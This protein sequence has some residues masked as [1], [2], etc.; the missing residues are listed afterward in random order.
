MRR[1]LALLLSTAC[2]GPGHYYPC[3][4]D[5]GG[6]CGVVALPDGGRTDTPFV[7]PASTVWHDN[8]HDAATDV[9]RFAG[10]LYVAFRHAAAWQADPAAQIFIVRSDD[11]GQSWS[12]VA[13]LTAAG[14]DLREP[15]IFLF[16]D[17]L[18]VI[19]T[20]WDTSDPSAHRTSIRTAFSDDGTKFTMPAD[21]PVPPGLAAWRPRVV[22][23]ALVL[24][25]WHADE[26]F[27][28]SASNQ[29][30]LLT[31]PDG[32]LFAAPPAPLTTSAGA[33]QGEL[34]V[35]ASG[36]SWL[37]LPER[38]IDGA[39]DRQTFCH[40][41]ALSD[42]VCW[43][44]T[45]QR[46]DGPALFEWNGV[47]FLAGRHDIGGGRKRTAVWQ[48][49]EDDHG[50]SLIA[51][52]AQSFGDTGGPGV[53]QLDADHALLTFHSTSTLDPRLAALGH[54]PTEVESQALG[55]AADV[56]AVRLYMPGAA[57]G[58]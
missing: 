12:K 22:G 47:L 26:L 7:A 24:A 39:P 31:S 48:V 57:A 4:P 34:L 58:R 1:C 32:L 13:A 54:E 33:R 2:A 42:W 9:V 3:D 40:S 41:K 35:R 52:L 45:G 29:L 25:A 23:S 16:H 50:L 19:A 27:P 43:S 5:A 6:D 36:D 56:L 49:I 10:A 46:V 51:D 17:K 53:V 30:G 15:K 28:A 18:W 20:A 55:L 44:V 37:A 14:R 8:Q 38:A 11:E 21:L